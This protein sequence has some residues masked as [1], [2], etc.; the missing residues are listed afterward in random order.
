MKIAIRVDS[1]VKI[2]TGHVM[3]CITLAN[4]LRKNGAEVLFVCRKHDESM[5]QFIIGKGFN[6]E[7]LNISPKNIVENR[8]GKYNYKSMLEIS[9]MEDAENT[10]EKIRYFK[11]NWVIVDH[12]SLGIKWEQIIKKYTNKIFV[13]DDIANRRHDCDVLL[14][15]NLYEN[16]HSRYDNLIPEGC[17]KLL[18]PKYALLRSE[19]INHRKNV[20]ITNE[21]INSVF[22][23]FGGTDHLNLTEITLRSLMEKKLSHLTFNVVIGKDNPNKVSIQK[24]SALHKNINLIIQTN[25]IGSIMAKSDIAIGS[26]GSAIWEICCLGLP[27]FIISFADNQ[28]ESVRHLSKNNI[29]EYHCHFDE[30]KPAFLNQSFYKFITNNSKINLI[31]KQCF[32]V[33]DG[34][35]KRRIIKE[36][37]FHD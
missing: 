10:I 22:I 6:V 28:L 34:L 25:E 31:R 23:F 35:G 19:F 36:F 9:E 17:K 12:Y 3:R 18:G 14:D 13:I 26:G 1:S 16:M 37:S 32:G 8:T 24:F 27:S 7:Q 21:D 15:Q 5:N 30:L 11:P 4:S 2:G 33:V 29:I 20:Q